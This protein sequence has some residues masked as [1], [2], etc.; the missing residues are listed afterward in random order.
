MPITSGCQHPNKRF[1]T[2][3]RQQSAQVAYGTGQLLVVMVLHN[4]RT[5]PPTTPLYVFVGRLS[6]YSLTTQLLHHVA[7]TTLVL[8]YWHG[9][10]WLLTLVAPGA[11]CHKL[12][13][14]DGCK[15]RNH[16]KH[17][18]SLVKAISFFHQLPARQTD[19]YR[20]ASSGGVPNKQD[21]KE[22]LLVVPCL[23]HSGSDTLAWPLPQQ[24]Q[25]PA[26][27]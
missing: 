6:Y 14:T 24:T 13:H 23:K 19:H 12:V 21:R 15:R 10:Y 25:S 2:S 17:K 7:G 3:T 18:L 5:P 26:L 4:A 1:P 20:S 16:L 11:G 8:S 27:C 22:V 9:Q